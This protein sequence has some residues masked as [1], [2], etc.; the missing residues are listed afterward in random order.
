M[1]P[2]AH[3]CA[4]RDFTT[5]SHFSAGRLG[6]RQ[7]PLEKLFTSYLPATILKGMNPEALMRLIEDFEA[8]KEAGNLLHQRLVEFSKA[9][10]R[11]EPMDEAEKVLLDHLKSLLDGTATR[12]GSVRGSTVGGG[13][14]AAVHLALIDLRK[15]PEFATAFAHIRRSKNL[16]GDFGS[17][18]NGHSSG[19]NGHAYSVAPP[20]SLTE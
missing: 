4:W 14:A 12:L 17:G 9:V 5:S 19:T 1:G 10:A 13:A 15:T 18:Q 20:K 2:K 16:P 8:F 11:T 3:T 6:G 7:I